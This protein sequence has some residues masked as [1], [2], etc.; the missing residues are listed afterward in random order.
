ML[1][2]VLLILGCIGK[3]NKFFKSGNSLKNIEADSLL[4]NHWVLQK[5]NGIDVVKEKA[6]NEIPYLKFNLSDS[7]VS[8]YT[9][10]NEIS[11]KAV[12]SG[13]EIIFEEISMSKIYCPDAQYE[14]DIL[15]VVFY[16]GILKYKIDSGTLSLF[17]DEVEI[18]IFKKKD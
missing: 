1:I 6:G 11:G 10:C 7:G 12:V 8:G 16:K 17:K 2:G 14:R 18:M 5:L 13:D 15:N 3:D 4:N 9:G